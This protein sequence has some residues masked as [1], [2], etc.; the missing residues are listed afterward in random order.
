MSED[1]RDPN[2]QA[3]PPAS[4]DGGAGDGGT[5][6]PAEVAK[7]KALA[8]KHEEQAKA[9]ADAARRLQEIEDAKKSELEK[10][11]EAQTAAERRAAEAEQRALRLEVA[12]EK[13]L[14]PAQ[15]KRLVGAT[16][17]ELEADA[18]ELLASF[19]PPSDGTGETDTDL[20]RRPRE[21]L[22]AGATSVTE[23]E[24]TDPRKLAAGLRSY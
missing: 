16:K 17:E 21:R 1:E 24:E 12:A 10:L 7:W 13:G 15:A 3:D 9:N 11:T 22:R 18:D 6:D 8:R 4:G 23:P 20:P 2:E 5:G 14:T 19:L